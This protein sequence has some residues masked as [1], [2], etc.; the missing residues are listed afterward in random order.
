ML[1]LLRQW[2]VFM[3]LGWIVNIGEKEMKKILLSL[4]VM[5]FACT[6]VH[7]VEAFSLFKKT[8][9]QKVADSEKKAEKAR[10]K[11]ETERLEAFFKKNKEVK[12][13]Y[14]HLRSSLETAQKEVSKSNDSSDQHYG[15]TES[16]Q[17][18]AVV[19]RTLGSFVEIIKPV[20]RGIAE[21]ADSKAKKSANSE[22][23][24]EQATNS[25]LEVLKLKTAFAKAITDFIRIMRE[26][27]N[28][29]YNQENIA[30]AIT[31]LKRAV[32]TGDGKN[33]T[34]K[35]IMTDYEALN[36][37]ADETGD[38]NTKQFL[39]DAEPA[40][41]MCSDVYTAILP[42]AIKLII[43]VC[44][45]KK[46]DG[47]KL[48]DVTAEKFGLD[49]EVLESMVAV[50]DPDFETEESESNSDSEDEVEE[51]TLPKS[52][53]SKAT[54]VE[55]EEDEED[56][57]EEGEENS[58][59]SEALDSKKTADPV[60]SES[61][62]PNPLGAK[63]QAKS[64]LKNETEGDKEDKKGQKKSEAPKNSK[65]L[66]TAAKVAEAA[67]KMK[68]AGSKKN[69]SKNKGK[70][71]EID[72]AS[73]SKK[74]ESKNKGKDSEIDEASKPLQKKSETVKKGQTNKTPKVVQQ[75]KIDSSEDT[76]DEEMFEDE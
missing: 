19:E 37:L 50:P 31:K 42:Q 36:D 73:K 67:S 25:V 74:N 57:D 15:S 70:D 8:E 46:N 22:E 64:K 48:L 43:D 58:E 75:Q 40:F 66:K 53:K 41:K 55:K 13:D 6:S 16:K 38:E 60:A 56:D 14:E 49:R 61:A 54:K 47:S 11:R 33:A 63:K 21:Y 23:R 24:Q 30:K 59:D 18:S 34:G 52:K 17:K 32:V 45:G 2:L 62:Q 69:E 5:A 76:D 28:D 65:K 35:D 71:S 29:M 1:F 4:S 12:K 10:S 39:R 44:D 7:Y 27:E 68:K 51:A 72:E 20:D 9:E 3:I 26:E